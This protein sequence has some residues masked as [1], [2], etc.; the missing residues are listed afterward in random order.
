MPAHMGANTPPPE[1]GGPGPYGPGPTDPD[2]TQQGG[3]TPGPDP[4][5]AGP[6]GVFQ[7]VGTAFGLYGA[8]L[9]TLWQVMAIV[10]IPLQVVVF[11]LRDVTVPSG[12]EIFNGKLYVFEGTDGGFVAITAVGYLLTALIVLI[13]IGAAYRILLGR[14][15]H[16]PADLRTSFG[17]AVGRAG[18]LLWLSIITGVLVLVGFILIIVPGIYLLV[19][20]GIAVPVLMAEDRRGFN[21]LGRSRELI[22]DNWWHVLGCLIVAGIVAGFGEVVI[23]LLLNPLVR[24]ISP[25]SITGFLII[26]SVLNALLTILFTPFTAAV[27][28]VM[29][30]DMLG[31]K[32]DPQL[33]RLLD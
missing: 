8:D 7:T 27:A 26:G 10:V 23:T 6:L 13:S 20:F 25:H 1:F 32:N 9:L 33:Q 11:L 24:A 5:V 31:R 22:S 30:V 19:A 4:R 28:V 29:Y 16:H 3:F 14:H 12:A 15:L 21:A 17:F 18:S 2:G